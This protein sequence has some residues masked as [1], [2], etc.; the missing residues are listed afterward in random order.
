MS[1]V[2]DYSKLTRRSDDTVEDFRIDCHRQ[3]GPPLHSSLS[4]VGVL[5][6]QT[7]SGFAAVAHS[8]VQAT[9]VTGVSN[10]RLRCQLLLESQLLSNDVLMLC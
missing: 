8:T 4:E 10:R 2:Y 9:C 5:P 1:A 3:A 7:D 6:C